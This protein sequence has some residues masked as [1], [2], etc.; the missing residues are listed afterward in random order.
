M[1]KAESRREEWYGVAVGTADHNG[2]ALGVRP[3]VS[4]SLEV[5]RVGVGQEPRAG[6]LAVSGQGCSWSG[7]SWWREVMVHPR[8]RMHSRLD[9]FSH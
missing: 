8:A 9:G 2:K 7:K 1:R 6:G 4:Q 3:V 5:R